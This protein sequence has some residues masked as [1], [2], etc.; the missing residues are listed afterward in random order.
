MSASQRRKGAAG[1]VELANLLCDLLGMSL[2]RQLGQERDGGADIRLGRA[3]IQVKRCETLAIPAWW[4]QAVADA[5]DGLPV[6]AWRQSR[7]GWTF[8][9]PL[10]AV[11]DSGSC[12]TEPTC[13]MH[14]WASVP[15]ALDAR[16]VRET[17]DK[18]LRRTQCTEIEK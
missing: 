16:L 8:R 3:H 6:L 1:E 11:L 7:K 5:G 10:V 13:D 2:K 18:A 9:V 14:T 17:A 12:A 4:R 15:D